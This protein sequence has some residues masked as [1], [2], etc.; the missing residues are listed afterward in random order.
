[1]PV[2]GDKRCI[3]VVDTGRTMMKVCGTTWVVCWFAALT[4]VHSEMFTAVVDMKQMLNAEYDVSRLIRSY[5][6]KQQ[7]QLASL[8]RYVKWLG[9]QACFYSHFV[10]LP[11]SNSHSQRYLFSFLFSS[12]FRINFP[13]PPFPFPFPNYITSVPIPA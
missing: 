11:F 3:G 2:L 9:L 7:N 4:V 10:P 6:K 13:F 5:V 12:S 1:M 8:S